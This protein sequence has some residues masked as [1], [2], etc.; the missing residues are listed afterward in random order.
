MFTWDTLFYRET[1]SNILFWSCIKYPWLHVRSGLRLTKRTL[2]GLEEGGRGAVLSSVRGSLPGTHWENT[3]RH[4]H[5]WSDKHKIKHDF[6]PST[7]QHLHQSL[8]MTQ[9]CSD[10]L[11]MNWR[12]HEVRSNNLNTISVDWKK[13]GYRKTT[14]REVSDDL[15]FGL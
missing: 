14:V 4:N 12:I 7:P 2:T 11:V 3:L 10:L 6:Y 9:S 13:W 1:I 5:W 8:H 15:N